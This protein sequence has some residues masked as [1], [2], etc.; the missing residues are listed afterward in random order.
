MSSQERLLI[1]YDGLTVQLGR[2][3][4]YNV[5]LDPRSDLQLLLLTIL[6][7]ENRPGKR[8]AHTSVKEGSKY[9]MTHNNPNQ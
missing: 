7:R 5:I 9:I 6:P 4:V 2:F 1:G 8:P 3:F